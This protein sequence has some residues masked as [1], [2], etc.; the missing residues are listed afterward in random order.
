MERCYGVFPVRCSH[1]FGW[2]K[3]INNGV[4]VVY[5]DQGSPSSQCG[6]WWGPGRGN[7]IPIVCGRTVQL[8]D[9]SKGVKK[10]M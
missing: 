4:C 9:E 3:A 10:G 8:G 1:D 6:N 7:P 2:R 5:R